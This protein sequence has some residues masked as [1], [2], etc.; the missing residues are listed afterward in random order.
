MSKRTENKKPKS[1]KIPDNAERVELNDSQRYQSNLRH[2]IDLENNKTEPIIN[3]VDCCSD[4]NLLATKLDVPDSITESQRKLELFDPSLKFLAIYRCYYWSKNDN[5]RKGKIFLTATELIFKCSRMPFVKLRLNFSDI[6]NVVKIKNYKHKFETVVSIDTSFGCSYA[7]YKFL[8]P[9]TVVRTAI[10]QLIE[11]YKRVNNLGD[12]EPEHYHMMKLRK[13]GQP[14]S[15]L[16]G[17]FKQSVKKNNSVAIE[18][19]KNQI[20]TENQKSNFKSLR[21]LK[22][23][24]SKL[25]EISYQSEKRKSSR[26]FKKQLSKVFLSRSYEQSSQDESETKPEAESSSVASTLDSSDEMQISIQISE[27]ETEIDEKN[28]VVEERHI[29]IRHPHIFVETT[30]IENFKSLKSSFY[31]TLFIS[32]I[33]IV[34]FFVLAI[35]NCVKLNLIEKKILELI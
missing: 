12:M 8:M 34:I 5:I 17:V 13:F 9:K 16:K 26:N 29:E 1:P 30:S 25:S 27:I 18:E 15:N 35:N 14:I 21:K 23:D 28:Q 19:N 20:S 2:S 11:E 22:L 24:R 6:N 7:F 32:F 33:S 31:L 4:K 10:L 3:L